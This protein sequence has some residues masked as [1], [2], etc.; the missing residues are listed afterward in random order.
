MKMFRFILIVAIFA[1][2]SHAALAKT[3]SA[4][5]ETPAGKPEVVADV[6]SLAIYPSEIVLDDG[7]DYQGVIAV[8]TRANGVT[9]DVSDQVEW[10]VEGSARLEGHRL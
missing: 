4:P 3:S 8:A 10:V 2:A 7:D 5:G 1:S 6:A 9:L